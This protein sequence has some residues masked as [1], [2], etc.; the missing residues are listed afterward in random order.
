[1][2]S[3]SR[4]EIVCLLNGSCLRDKGELDQLVQLLYRDLHRLARHYLRRERPDHTLQTTALVNEAYVRLAHDGRMQW[5]NRA[6]FVAVAARAMRRILVEHARS[7]LCG[8]RGFGVLKISIEDASIPADERAAD[9]VALD[10]A[11]TALEI[12]DR[13]KCRI[14]ELRFIGGLSIEET[15]E[16]LEVSTATV[17]REWRSAKAWLYQA[18]H[19]DRA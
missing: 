16:V 17:E 7:R 9:I 15:A 3:A 5:N 13:R 4:D 12:V 10:E 6:H 8:K 19:G 14:V 11:L 1:M 18:L 2:T